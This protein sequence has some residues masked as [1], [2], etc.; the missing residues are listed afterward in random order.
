M[1][2]LNTKAML[3]TNS[4]TQLNYYFLLLF[5]LFR[6]LNGRLNL[7][8]IILEVLDLTCLSMV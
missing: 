2:N 4:L 1:D 3:W 5:I 8:L 7:V 6:I